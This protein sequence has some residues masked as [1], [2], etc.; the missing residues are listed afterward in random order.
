GVSRVQKL[1]MQTQVGKNV[2]ISGIVG[3]FDDAQNGVKRIFSDKKIAKELD[4]A[5]VFLSSANSINFGRLVPQIVY[6]ISAYCDLVN[7]GAIRLGEAIDVTVPTGNFGNIFAA[8]IAKRMGIPF[9]KLVCASNKNSVLTDFIN[10]GV[11]DKN[12]AFYTTM[13]PSMDILIS[14]NLE[15]LLYL[16][17]GAKKCRG[18][19]KEL[20]E[21]GAYRVSPEDLALI[22]ESFTAYSTDEEGTA[23]TLK[24]LYENKSCLTDTH[25]SVAFGAAFEFM[26]N[27]KADR[28]MLTVSTA[29]PYKF[30]ADVY[31]AITAKSPSGDIEALT[32]LFE[33]SGVEIPL[34]LRDLDKREV[35]HGGVISRDGMENATVEFAKN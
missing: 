10:T 12:R 25:T 28:K 34:P 1:Q 32:E 30:A 9:D 31:R 23:S 27:C 11:Y 18:Y 29:S 15:R 13:S 20:N 33:L 22:Q 14:S 16:L 35:V 4:S 8:Y 3:N 17:L 2:S 19:M 26:N 21:R 6:Y 7:M 5:G 24:F